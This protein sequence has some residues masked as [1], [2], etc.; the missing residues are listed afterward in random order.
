MKRVAI[1]V[2]Y[3]VYN[4]FIINYVLRMEK[5]ISFEFLKK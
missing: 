5:I 3:K 2:R 4:I 1:M